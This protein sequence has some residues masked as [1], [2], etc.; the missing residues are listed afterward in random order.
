MGIKYGEI[1]V[2]TVRVLFVEKDY[3]E[4]EL[5]QKNSA[6]EKELHRN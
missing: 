2:S 6:R 1:L 4:T 3:T 5:N